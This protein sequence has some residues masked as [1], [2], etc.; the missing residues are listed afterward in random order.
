MSRYFRATAALAILT[1]AATSVAA[2]EFEPG[3]WKE[4]ETGTENGRPVE[5][6]VNT[7]CM[8]DDEAKNPVKGLSPEKD[9]GEL[10]GHC[11]TL[12]V[13]TSETGLS[14]RLECGDPKQ[15]QMAFNV[16]YIFNNDKSYTGTVKSVVTMSGKSSTSEKKIEGRWMSSICIRKRAEEQR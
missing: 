6:A 12:D 1:A 10:R 4:I 7:S 8:S 11:K 2:F 13:K 15:V 3:A 16:S 14:M 9:L 5:P